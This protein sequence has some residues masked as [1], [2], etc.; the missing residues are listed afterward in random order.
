MHGILSESLLYIRNNNNNNNNN[1][2]IV[3]TLHKGDNKGN[4][5]RN[6]KNKVIQLLFINVLSQ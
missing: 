4:N 2:I 1:H 5:K 6:N 3:N